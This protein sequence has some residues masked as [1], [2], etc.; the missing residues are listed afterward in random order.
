MDHITEIKLSFEMC[1]A[2]SKD[3]GK[4]TLLWLEPYG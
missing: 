3:A 2:R 1:S 4:E